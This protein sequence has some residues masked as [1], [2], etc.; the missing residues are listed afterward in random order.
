MFDLGKS[1]SAT[2]HLAIPN[3]RI[4]KAMLR[5]YKYILFRFKRI[6]I[7]DVGGCL[8]VHISSSQRNL[9]L[10]A[11]IPCSQHHQSWWCHKFSLFPWH[12]CRHVPCRFI[13]YNLRLT[14]FI[15]HTG[16]NRGCIDICQCILQ[17]G[18]S[19]RW[20]KHFSLFCVACLFKLFCR[21]VYVMFENQYHFSVMMSQH[22]HLKPW[23]TGL[24]NFER[25]MHWDAC[26][27][28]NEMHWHANQDALTQPLATDLI[29]QVDA[30]YG[31]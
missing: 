5:I 2:I 3:L 11:R 4:V 17:V 8:Y 20:W 26:C 12:S 31:L 13:K 6:T 14:I 22:H 16:M 29:K 30:N 15:K 19:Q 21:Y 9:I 10:P 24:I 1:E 27:M 28:W 18:R 23:K 25:E 7:P